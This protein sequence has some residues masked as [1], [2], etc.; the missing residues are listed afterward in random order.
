MRSLPELIQDFREITQQV[1]FA[2]LVVRFED[3]G[4][5]LVF[6]EETDGPDPLA[7]V[8]AL[9]AAGGQPVAIA[10]IY[11]VAGQGKFSAFALPEYEGLPWMPKYLTLIYEAFE[12]WF[13][14][15]GFR[16]SGPIEPRPERN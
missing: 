3:R 16:H 14:E 6:R 12:A 9:V 7:A 1:M 13:D 4:A 8:N 15:R 11:R 2:A 5:E 10:V